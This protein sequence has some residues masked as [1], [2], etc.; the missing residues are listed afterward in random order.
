MGI[1]NFAIVLPEIIASLVFGWVMSHLLNNNRVLA[2]MAGGVFMILAAA[3]MSRVRDIT[4]EQ[5]APAS[6]SLPAGRVTEHRS[7]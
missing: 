2:V 6:A 3:L 4:A 5:M 7:R 1:F